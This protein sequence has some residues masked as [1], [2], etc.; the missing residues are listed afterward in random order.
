MLRTMQKMVYEG[1]GAS[2][3]H[4]MRVVAENALDATSR[5]SLNPTSRQKIPDFVNVQGIYARVLVMALASKMLTNKSSLP[6]ITN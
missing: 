2:S 5:L 3:R 1:D 4:Y 6:K